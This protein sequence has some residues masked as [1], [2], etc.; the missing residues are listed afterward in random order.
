M[1]RNIPVLEITKDDELELWKLTEIYS[2]D[3]LEWFTLENEV[4]QVA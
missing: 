3:K 2:Y 4:Q 1:I